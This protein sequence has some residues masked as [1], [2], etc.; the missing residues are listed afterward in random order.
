[1]ILILPVVCESKDYFDAILSSC[2]Q[3]A[4][5]A[6]QALGTIVKRP[7]GTIPNLESRGNIRGDTMCTS[8]PQTW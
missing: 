2:F 6:L 4:V 8:T 3:N 1:M 5:E 7:F